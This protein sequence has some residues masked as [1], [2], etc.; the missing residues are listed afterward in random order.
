MSWSDSHK[1]SEELAAAAHQAL[2]E[3]NTSVAYSLFVEAGNA[4]EQA[5]VQLSANAQPRTFGITAVSTAALWYKGGKLDLAEAVAH[6][7]L[8]HSNVEA[9][10]VSQ[11]RTLLQAIWN[12]R[13]QEAAGIK[14]AP[15]QVQVSVKGGQVVAGGA[16]LDLIVEKVQT[17]QSLFYRTTEWLKQMPL[18]RNGPAPKEIQDSCRP[19]LFQGVP[20][21]YQFV[22]AIQSTRQQDWISPDPTTPELVASTFLSILKNAVED[23]AEGLS[24]LVPNKEY[25]AAFLKLT[26]S[27]SPIGTLFGQMEV[28][29]AGDPTPVVLVPESRKVIAQILRAEAPPSSDDMV[30]TVVK[31]I[32]RAVHLDKDWLE[33]TVDGGKGVRVWNVGEALDDVIGPMVNHPVSVQVLKDDKEKLHFRDI[34]REE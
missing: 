12:V 31:G 17:I 24:R 19:W 22:V 5:L 20:S 23:P 2:R 13:A 4:E 21:S 32:L 1:L 18:R 16:P 15:G 7:I 8:A 33:V 9:S 28:R 30:P 29:A 27:L 26:R 11:L 3:G 10:A 25:K 6:R 14:F 34:E